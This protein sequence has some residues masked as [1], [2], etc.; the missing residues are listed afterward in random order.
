MTTRFRGGV[1]VIEKHGK[2]SDRARD[3]L[4]RSRRALA[5]PA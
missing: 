4:D 1:D 5:L 2:L 3:L